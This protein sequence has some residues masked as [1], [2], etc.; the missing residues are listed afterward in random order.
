MDNA[1]GPVEAGMGVAGAMDI[2]VF[3]L[4]SGSHSCRSVGGW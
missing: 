4:N 1:D 3:L 2:S